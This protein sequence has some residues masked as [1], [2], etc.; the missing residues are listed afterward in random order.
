MIR[1]VA[2][3]AAEGIVP[4]I[5]PPVAVSESGIARG[6]AGLLPEGIEAL[7]KI[8]EGG[9]TAAP[10]AAGRTGVRSSGADTAWP[11]GCW[12]GSWDDDEA[13]QRDRIGRGHE[14]GATG[15]AEAPCVGSVD[16]RQ[17]NAG[18]KRES[19]GETERDF[20][21]ATPLETNLPARI[22][23]DAG[24]KL[25][26]SGI[27]RVNACLLAAKTPK[28]RPGFALLDVALGPAAAIGVGIMEIGHAAGVAI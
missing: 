13:S 16:R 20:H 25:R 9:A 27:G 23:G 18:R 19:C 4:A 15:R 17:A 22:V 21:V 12:K 11:T 2:E 10:L 8:D 14:D 6:V 24:Q 28:R 5:S 26:L 7:R 3:A 1:L